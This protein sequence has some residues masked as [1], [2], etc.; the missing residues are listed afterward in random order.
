MSGISLLLVAGEASGDLHGARLLAELQ[1]LDP[2]IRA[3]GLGGGEL[4]RAGLEAVS[5]ENIAV[6][7]ITEVLKILAKAKEVFRQVLEE[8]DRRRPRAAVLVDF[9]EFNLRLAKE[10]KARGIP[11]IYYISPQVWAWRRRRVKQ[12]AQRVDLMLVL[13]PFEAAFYEGHDIAVRHV[14]H[15]LIDEVPELDHIW[16]GG[17][18][19]DGVFRIAL[20]PGSRS[21]ELEKLLPR[22]LETI[23]HLKKSLPVRPMVIRAATISEQELRPYLEAFDE[24][25]EVVSEDRFSVI[26]H[27][28]LA[29][30]ASGTATLE[31]GLL[32]TPMIVVYRLAPWTYALAKLLVKVP[33]FSL[34]NLVL[35]KKVVPE[36]L[37][38]EAEPKRVAQRSRD[39]LTSPSQIEEMRH[40]LSQLRVKL[41]EKG[42]SRRAAAAVAPWLTVDGKA[43]P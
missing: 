20:L 3:F 29:L 2:S 21:S 38:G 14:G 31:T 15:P 22:M 13:F 18:P 19:V 10:L 32:G 35:G 39:L 28:H 42:A 26:S 8:V 30:C 7:G 36:L 23:R 25:L 24:P 33:F 16:D 1:R 27:C 41:G 37:Q 5:D 12:I 40:S 34:V 6:V 4:R 9:P 11:V 17:M 43:S